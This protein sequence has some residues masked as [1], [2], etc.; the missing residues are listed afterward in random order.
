MA[1]GNVGDFWTPVRTADSKALSV[2]S[3]GFRYDRLTELVLTEKTYRRPPAMIVDA[4]GGERWQLIVRGVAAGQ[5]K[6]E[7]YYER[8]DIVLSTATVRAFGRREEHDRLATYAQAQLE[9][10]EDVMKALRFGIAVA[11]GGGPG[12]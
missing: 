7:G 8:T 2:S 1:G 5:G 10:V 3:V 6:T 9:E 12:C 11:A 4:Q